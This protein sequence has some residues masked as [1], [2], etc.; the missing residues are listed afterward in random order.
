MF[1]FAPNVR[2]QR[3]KQEVNKNWETEDDGRERQQGLVPDVLEELKSIFQIL[4]TEHGTKEDFISL[5]HLVSSKYPGI[6][7]TSS[8]EVLNEHVRENVLFPISDKELDS[9]W[10]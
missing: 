7:G 10:V 2:E 9:L 8:Q 1:G 4:E 3:V 5:F 6:K